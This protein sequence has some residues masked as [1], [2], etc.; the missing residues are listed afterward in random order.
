MPEESGQEPESPLDQALD[1]K[2]KADKQVVMKKKEHEAKDFKPLDKTITPNESS[3]DIT[4]ADPDPTR[5][6]NQTGVTKSKSKS[7]NK[8]KN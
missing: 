2:H 5:P 4:E 7:K 8:N 1:N 6:P 3:D